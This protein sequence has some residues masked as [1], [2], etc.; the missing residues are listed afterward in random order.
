[1]KT[2]YFLTGTDT[3]IGKTLISCALLHHFAAQ[4]QR[5][6]GM[7][8]VAAGVNVE[9]EYDDVVQLCAASNVS[10]ALRDIN[11]YAFPPA[12]AP[13]LAAQQAGMRIEFAPILAAFQTLAQQADTVI[14]EGV[15]GWRVP[16]NASQDSANLAKALNLPVILVVG[17]RLGCLSHALLTVESI[18]ASGLTLAGWVA[19]CVDETMT[20][21][22]ENIAALQQR[23]DAPLLGIV[24]FQ[25]VP[26]A[27]AA[28]SYLSLAR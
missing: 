20:M 24:P 3:N 28:A 7:K 14:V 25:R 6:I 21:R 18:A 19:N 9:G 8:P 4:G 1:M 23:I 13:H 16:L 17:M 15:G 5:V 12:I 10:A 22:E 27:K 26:D 2:T 11:P